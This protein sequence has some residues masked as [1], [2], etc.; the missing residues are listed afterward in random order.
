[1][2]EIYREKIR[3]LLSTKPAPAVGLRMR[4]SPKQGFYGRRLQQTQARALS[5][6]LAA[7]SRGSVELARQRL[8]RHSAAH[9]RGN[10]NAHNSR[11][12]HERDKQ[13]VSER[14]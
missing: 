2:L 13:Q 11:H 3:D 1:M 7:C 8:Q 4:E 12:R 6:A 10:K 14:Q 5:L 9:R